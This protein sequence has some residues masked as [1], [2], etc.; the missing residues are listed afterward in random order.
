[1]VART[2]EEDDFSLIPYW[3]PIKP[4]E[5]RGKERNIG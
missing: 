1:M 3:I 5:I 4:G 2:A